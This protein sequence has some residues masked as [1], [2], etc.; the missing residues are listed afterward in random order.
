MVVC[1][2]AGDWG[3]LSGTNDC[4]ATSGNVVCFT[5]SA[6]Q[7]QLPLPASHLPS[8][9][10]ATQYQ[11]PLPASHLPSF[12]AAT[13]YQLPLPASHLPSFRAATQ[14]QLDSSC[15]S[16]TLIQGCYSIPARLF[17]SLT[18]PHSGLLLNTS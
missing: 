12:R 9:R 3:E 2:L 15:L 7:Y 5:S 13:Q 8:F 17:L 11:L 14:Y 18:Y 10:A 16:P 4:C 1:V 6:T